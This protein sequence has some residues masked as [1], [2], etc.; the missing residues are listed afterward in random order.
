MKNPRI[1]SM[2]IIETYLEFQQ[3]KSEF[4]VKEQVE[5]FQRSPVNLQE[6]RGIPKSLTE[7]FKCNELA[8]TSMRFH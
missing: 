1:V 5:A 3:E 8:R 7:T 2:D 4:E 6:V